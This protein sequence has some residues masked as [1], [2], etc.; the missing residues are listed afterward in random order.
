MH[1]SP[2]NPETHSTDQR[3]TGLW[4]LLGTAAVCVTVLALEYVGRKPPPPKRAGPPPLETIPAGMSLL[5]REYA[6][7]GNWTELLRTIERMS[8]GDDML[9]IEQHDYFRLAPQTYE[10]FGMH[11]KAATSYRKYLEWSATI[12]APQCRRCHTPPNGNFPGTLAEMTQSAGGERYVR[13]LKAE[14]QL[15]ATTKKVRVLVERAPNDPGPRLVLYH[16]LRWGGDSAGAAEQAQW[17]GECDVLL[18]TPASKTP[19]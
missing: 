2:E 15:A 9:P 16:L 1:V 14:H 4:V 12:H 6:G 10:R 11:A 13:Q 7:T 8:P 3:R 17:L 19:R 18:T 5:L